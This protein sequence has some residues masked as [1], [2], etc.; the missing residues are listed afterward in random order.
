MTK[1]NHQDPKIWIARSGATYGPYTTE[2]IREFIDQ[3]R[4]SKLDLAWDNAEKKWIPLHNL[5]DLSELTKNQETTENS[6]LIATE[7]AE[8]ILEL[9]DADR[10]EFAIDLLL[11]SQSTEV[12]EILLGNRMM[13]YRHYGIPRNEKMDEW[14]EISTRFDFELLLHCP[15]DAQIDPF[16]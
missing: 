9:L 2:S 7:K 6:D 10:E 13:R 12:F 14:L 3:G 4:C 5:L 15:E 1:Q 16:L 8:K 11:S